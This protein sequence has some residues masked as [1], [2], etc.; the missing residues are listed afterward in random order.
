MKPLRIVALVGPHDSGK[1]GLLVYLVRSL[2]AR[3]QKVGV[4]KR[5]ARPLAFDVA[6]K[7]SARLLQGGSRRVITQ[8]PGLVYTQEAVSR[9]RSVRELAAGSDMDWWLVESYEPERIPWV[10]VRRQGQ[11]A[12]ASDRFCVATFGA[13]PEGVTRPHFAAGRPARLLAFLQEHLPS[14]RRRA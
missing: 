7:D 8:S 10:L 11:P 13:R 9:P 3:G 12:P 6:G 4:I 5:A 1:T 2:S 14:G